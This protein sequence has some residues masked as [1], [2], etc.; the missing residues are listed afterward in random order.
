MMIVWSF[1][2]APPV[3]QQALSF[4]VLVDVQVPMGIYPDGV[5]PGIGWAGPAGQYFPID[6]QYGHE[7]VQLRNK[8]RVVRIDVNVTRAG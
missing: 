8:D 3:L 7:S 6:A 4:Q 1:L 2:L 5:G